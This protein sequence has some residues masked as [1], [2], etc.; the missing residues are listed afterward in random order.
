MASMSLFDQNS[1]QDADQRLQWYR[2]KHE[3]ERLNRFAI[4]QQTTILARSPAT[5]M[6]QL[7]F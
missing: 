2:G 3:P 7:E 5:S 4:A 1:R 6:L